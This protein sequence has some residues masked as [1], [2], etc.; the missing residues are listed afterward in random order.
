MEVQFDGFV[1]AYMLEQFLLNEYVKY[2]YQGNTIFKYTK[3]T[4][5][6]TEDI[7][8]MYLM[9]TLQWV[10]LLKNKYLFK[11]RFRDLGCIGTVSPIKVADTVGTPLHGDSEK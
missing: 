7:Y 10:K 6:F 5:V 9:E 4:E 11:K 2:K 1:D 8:Q 3:N